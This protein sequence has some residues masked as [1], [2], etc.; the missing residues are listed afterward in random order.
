ML[1]SEGYMETDYRF[2]QKKGDKPI[3]SLEDLKG[4][5]RDEKV[6]ANRILA[7]Q[8]GGKYHPGCS[9]RHP[10]LRA[11]SISLFRCRHAHS[12]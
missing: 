11:I 7:G 6:G 3:A 12:R 10:V 8:V 5:R 4:Y 9:A 2:L 1:F